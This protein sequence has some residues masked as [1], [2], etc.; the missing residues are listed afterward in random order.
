MRSNRPRAL[1]LVAAAAALSWI[2]SANAA[3]EQSTT[4]SNARLTIDALIDIK[5]PSNPVWSRDSRSI[6]F[7]WERAGVAN[8]FVVA[9][10]GSSA[11]RAVTKDGDPVAG[12]F[13]SADSETLYFLRGNVLMRAA[14]DGSEAPRAAWSP[15][16]GRNMVASRDGRRVAYLVGGGNGGGRGAGRGGRGRAD[17]PVAEAAPPPSVPTEIRVRSLDDDSD[18]TVATFERPVTTLAWAADDDHL[19]FTTGGAET[20][21]HE[22][23]PEVLRRED[24][25]HHHGAGGRRTSRCLPRRALGRRAREVQRRIRRRIR[26]PRKSLGR[27]EPLPRRSPER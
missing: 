7:M 11:P 25:L 24:H 16:P 3:R 5:H 13:W 22:Q 23:T 21:R 26:R 1:V 15:M 27:L 8:L 17:A 10:D 18:K 12:V 14:A 9:A 20:I 2:L 19:T 6:A 4:H